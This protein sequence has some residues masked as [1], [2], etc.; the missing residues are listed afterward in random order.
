MPVTVNKMNKKKKV[1]EKTKKGMKVVRM[2]LKK[3]TVIKWKVELLQI[4]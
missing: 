2:I 3:K 4:S 1:A